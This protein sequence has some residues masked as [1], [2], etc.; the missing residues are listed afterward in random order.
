MLSC[1]CARGHQKQI[2]KKTYSVELSQIELD[3]IKFL[4]RTAIAWDAGGPYGN[5]DDVDDKKGLAK[6]KRLLQKLE[7]CNVSVK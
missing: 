7:A 3:E 6:A 1:V 5:G 4:I 2:M